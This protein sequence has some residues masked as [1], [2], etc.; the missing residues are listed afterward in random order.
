MT[1]QG[2]IDKFKIEKIWDIILAVGEMCFIP[3]GGRG[4]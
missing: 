2:A 1:K 3:V 4:E